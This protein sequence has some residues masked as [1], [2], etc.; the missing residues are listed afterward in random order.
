QRGATQS[1]SNQRQERTKA[2]RVN[3]LD[4]VTST[5][6]AK[7]AAAATDSVRAEIFALGLNNHEARRE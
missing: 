3:H 2:P 7:L 5:D 6:M 1:G 4:A